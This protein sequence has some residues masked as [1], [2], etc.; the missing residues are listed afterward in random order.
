[1]RSSASTPV[2]KSEIC[3]MV[4]PT[5]HCEPSVKDIVQDYENQFGFENLNAASTALATFSG[6]SGISMPDHMVKEFEGLALLVTNLS[7][8][9][10]VT[11]I[12]SGV[13]LHLRAYIS[14]SISKSVYDYINNL[15]MIDS[16]SFSDQ[17]DLETPDWL[18]CLRDIKTNWKMCKSNRIFTQFSKLLGMCVVMGLCK[19][20]DVEFSIGKFKLFTP[21]IYDKHV[22]AFEL[23]DAFCETVMY[24]TESMYLCFKNKSLQPF[25]IN[26][27]AALS[28]DEECAR[29]FSWWDLVK[30]GNLSRFT[31]VSDQEFERR[32]NKLTKDLTNLSQSLR[33]LDKKLVVD[34]YTRCLNMQNDFITMKMA[35]GVRHAPFTFALYGE[36]SQG[37]TTLGDQ[38]VDA[39]LASASLPLDKSYRAA[40]NPSDKY[41]SNWTSDKLVMIFDDCSNEKSQFADRPPTRAILDVCNNQ[42][43]YANKAELDAKGRVFVEP[44]IAMATTN[45]KHLDAGLYSNCPYSIQRR[46]PVYTIVVKNAFQK[47][48]EGVPCGIDSAK[49]RNYYTIDGVYTPPQFDDIWSITI[50]HAVKPQNLTT[51][52]SYAPVMWRGREL[53]HIDMRTC[54]QYSIEAFAAHRENQHAI[55]DGMR[56]RTRAI[57]RCSTPHCCHLKGYCPDHE[58]LQFGSETLG[59]VRGLLR[60]AIPTFSTADTIAARV[61]YYAGKRYINKWCWVKFI[62]A[63]FLDNRFVQAFFKFIYF[64]TLK[65]DYIKQTCLL[66]LYYVLMILLSLYVGH[67]YHSPIA[68]FCLLF[69]STCFVLFSQRRMIKIVETSLIKRLRKENGL[70][71]MIVRQYRDDNVSY[72]CGIFIG[73]AGAYALCKAYRA[74]M[75]YKASVTPV[76]QGS[77]EP[78]TEDEIIKRDN[79]KSPW[80]VPIVRHLPISA[81]SKTVNADTLCRTVAKN[82]LY[83]SVDKPGGGTG[84]LNMLML[85]SNL[86]LVPQHYFDICGDELRCQFRRSNPETCGGNFY[87]TL[88]VHTSVHIPDTDYRVCYVTTGGSYANIIKHFAL[89]NSPSVPFIMQWRNRDGEIVE[90]KGFSETQIVTT[91]RTYMGGRY[92]NLTINTFKGLCGATL[93]SDTCGSFIMGMHLGGI[94]DTPRGCFGAVSQTQL[95]LAIETVKSI[96]GV[97][98]SGSAGAFKEEVYGIQMLTKAPLHPK[99]PINYLPLESQFEYLG[100]CTGRSTSKSDVKVTP[101]SD[102]IIDVC[103]VPNIYGP[104]KMNPEWHGWQT[105]MAN[106]SNPAREFPHDLLCV[107]VTDYKETLLPVFKSDLWSKATPLDDKQNINGIRGC[108]FVD[109][110]KLNTSIGYP[111]SGP[112]RDHIIGGIQAPEGDREFTPEIMSEITRCEDLYANGERAYTVAKAC[113]KDEILA[114]P[115]CRI[116]FGNAIS[117]TFLIRKYYLPLLR[118]LQMNPLK[119]ECAVGINSHG[120]EWDTFYKHVTQHGMDRLIGGDYGK[121]DQKLP[122]QLLLA[123][124]RCLIDFARLCKYSERDIAIMESLSGDLVYSLINFNG[125]L[126]ALTQGAHIS[127]NSLTVI[128]NGICGSLNMRCYYYH[129]VGI[130]Q[131]NLGRRFQQDVALMTYGDDNIGTASD[132]VDFS[133]KGMS[134]FLASYGQEY[135]MPDKTSELQDFLRPDQFEFLKRVNVYHPELQCNIGALLDKSIFKALHCFIRPKN[136]VNTPNMASALNIDGAL[137]EWFNHGE[138]L[139]EFRRLQM[140]EVAQRAGITHMCAELNVTFRDRVNTWCDIYL[141]NHDNDLSKS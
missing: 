5:M 133:I 66:W 45:V 132:R 138:E 21:D 19:H 107:A 13:I 123:A 136:C 81:V 75:S 141:Q 20:T 86:G 17:S 11:G 93:V 6:I 70:V 130:N 100:T 139:Y 119:S 90:S 32:L 76:V 84:A 126:I 9:T 73:L 103:N 27:H 71:H 118:V 37:K 67:Y 102:H 109:A 112:K 42:M 41:M 60:N 115:K 137:R 31:D 8:Q 113:K 52:A 110:I 101:I 124:M 3:D 95:F 15:F 127:G 83:G 39:L 69:L 53:K 47:F 106:M 46:M 28:L 22:N 12:V 82:L 57:E 94:S 96:E 68:G 36:S 62:P 121:Y 77:L 50:E 23:V 125:D 87:A 72:V 97:L 108:K 61:L 116:F 128:I 120:P 131:F 117:L 26:D 129:L 7:Q 10:T 16:E 111:L 85:N 63:H 79:E 2:Y 105:C 43:Y 134:E 38:L 55:L 140:I 56:V 51:V 99:S 25:L 48:V 114:K 18:S 122:S 30:H 91:T 14:T 89:S 33:G 35:S 135:T 104:P 58:D 34:K 98:I 92:S 24:F 65:I 1:M 74:Y 4:N 78:T 54:I 59:A 64:D 44:W 88:S 49:V 29:I 40:Y 80:C